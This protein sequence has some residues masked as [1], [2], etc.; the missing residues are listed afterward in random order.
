M[1]GDGRLTVQWEVPGGV[2]TTNARVR[3]DDVVSVGVHYP[4]RDVVV[5]SDTCRRRIELDRD[6][7][8]WLAR[9]LTNWLAN[10][11]REDITP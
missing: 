2:V 10:T 4:I 7:A 5:V 6:D 8:A 9:E 11:T 3:D 1:T